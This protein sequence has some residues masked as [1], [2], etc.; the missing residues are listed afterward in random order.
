MPN[1]SHLILP[2]QFQLLTKIYYLAPAPP[3][4]HSVLVQPRTR[5]QLPV[6][7]RS[8]CKIIFTTLGLSLVIRQCHQCSELL[9]ASVPIAF[10]CFYSRF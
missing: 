2:L 7:P 6:L 8:T 5:T 3:G 1:N 4:G 9:T 10:N